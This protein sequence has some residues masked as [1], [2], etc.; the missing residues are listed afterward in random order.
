MAE[1]LQAS[2]RPTLA[3]RFWAKVDR[4]T[5]PDGCWEWQAA[6]NAGGYGVIRGEHR[7]MLLAHRVSLALD[8]RPVPPG[9]VARHRCDN[10]C[11]VNPAHLLHGTH[12]DNMADA[13]ERGSYAG[14][15]NAQS[16]ITDDDVHRIR[17]LVREG[18]LLQ[19]EIGAM[20]GIGQV[21]VSEIASGVKWRHLAA[22]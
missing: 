1:R 4:T 6:R 10:P 2:P 8:G 18:R 5:D 15:R 13:R 17:E 3:E 7:E 14:I 11:C 21:S 19:R 22:A 20:F 12:A 9:Q 16:K